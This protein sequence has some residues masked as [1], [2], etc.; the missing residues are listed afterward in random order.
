MRRVRLRTLLVIL[1]LVTTLP[2]A[3]F[4][5][6]VISQFSAQQEAII[7]RQNVDQARAV[8]VAVDQELES[9]VAAL[10][11]LALL[12]PVDAP[13]KADFAEIAAR[14]LPLHPGWQ[15]I[16]LID[17]NLNVL[18]ATSGPP[19]DAPIVT[20]DWVRQVIETGRPAFSNATELPGEAQWT[21]NVGVPVNRGGRVKY[22]LGARVYAQM[23]SALLQKQKAP[24]DGVVTLLDASPH[25]I[26]RTRNEDRYVGQA[27]TA[28]FV[29]RSRATA[30]GSWRARMLEGTAAYSAWSRSEVSGWTVGIGLPAEPIDGPIRRSFR[31]LVA[32][33][34]LMFGA[35]VALALVL[36]RGLIRS[37]TAAAAAAQALARGVPAARFHSRIEEA[38]ALSEGLRDAAIV[39]QER[40]RERDAAQAEADRNRAALLDREKSARRAAETLNHAKD[41][42][43][44]TVSHE[45]R[46]PLNAIFGWVAMLRTGTLDAVRQT[47]ALDVIDRNT[48]AQSQLVEDLLDMS[49]AIQGGVRLGM[50][51]LDLAVVLEAAIESLRPTADARQIAIETT[52]VRGSAFVSGDQGRVQQ[53]L[54]N[55]LSNALKFTP[56]G[57]RIDAAVGVED[58][59][60]F[61]RI[62]DSGEGIAAEFLPHVFDRFRQENASVTRTHSGLGLGLSLVRHLVE[63]HGGTIT[64]E[65]EGKGFGATFTIRFPLL[66]AGALTGAPGVATSSAFHDPASLRGRQLLVVDDDVDTRELAAELLMLAGATVVTAGSAADAIAAVAAQVPDAIVADIG[67]PAVSGY[68]LARQLRGDPRLADLPLVALTA[69]GGVEARDAA[70][71]SGFSAYMRKPYDPRALAALLAGL[72]TANDP[73]A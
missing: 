21:L 49:R 47:H 45:L 10:S 55:L 50:E 64:A 32:A 16:R 9:T 36:G 13:D 48:R 3:L 70:L 56:P 73:A 60:A 17:T 11:V 1:V 46:T 65:S 6:W 62:R 51:P 22:V 7:D 72:I 42:F 61:V 68:D 12:D 30:E 20:P 53:V 5:T 28:E 2:V 69:Y 67:M 19:A 66:G 26:A 8:L 37:H 39:L 24:P 27:P 63:L 44:A 71:A 41:E 54:W 52:T 40:E 58:S 33:G 25:I 43:I 15:S 59:D 38:H 35:G 23:F 57:G 14:V 29:Q 4:A 31:A 18:A 34:I